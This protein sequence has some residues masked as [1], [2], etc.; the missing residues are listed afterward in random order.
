VAAFTAAL[1][2]RLFKPIGC[3]NAKRASAFNERAFVHRKNDEN[4]AAMVDFAGV[5]LWITPAFALHA[6]CGEKAG[7]PAFRCRQRLPGWVEAPTPFSLWTGRGAL[8][9]ES[10]LH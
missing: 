10:A 5:A 3:F 8:R 1:P 4:S 2:E 7:L 6:T 9:P